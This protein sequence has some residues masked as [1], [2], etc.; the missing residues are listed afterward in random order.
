[1]TCNA[2]TCRLKGACGCPSERPLFGEE[3]RVARAATRLLEELV[4]AYEIRD[5][6]W[7]DGSARSIAR[8]AKKLLGPR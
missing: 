1:M 4:D 3:A 8:E 5:V 6:V 7:F 2:A